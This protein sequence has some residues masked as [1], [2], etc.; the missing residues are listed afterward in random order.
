MKKNIEKKNA[1]EVNHPKRYNH[2]KYECIDVIEDLNL[3]FNI[4]SA[5]KYLWRLGFKN[6]EI[7]E[8]EKAVWYLQH[9]IQRRKNLKN[10]EK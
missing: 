6:D 5:M 10:D 8:L 3:N 1:D 2:G 9:E 4:G 7:N